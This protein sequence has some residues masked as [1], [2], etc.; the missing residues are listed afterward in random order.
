[1][2]EQADGVPLPKA[3]LN[4]AVPARENGSSAK[5]ALAIRG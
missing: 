3:G 1:M 2:K 4:S 5:P